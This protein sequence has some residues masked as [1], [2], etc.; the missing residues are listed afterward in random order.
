MNKQEILK[1]YVKEAD[2]LLVA[3]ILDKVQYTNTRNKV[4]YSDFL[5][6]Y[7]QKVGAKILKQIDCINVILCGGYE[8]AERK[9]M[10]FL[11]EKLQSFLKV[12][13]K[14]NIIIQDL[15]NVI[16]IKLP[17]DL[18]GKYHHRDYLS[19]LMKLGIRREKL[20]DILVREDGADIL[21]EKDLANYLIVNL[22]ELTRFK[23][24]S[25]EQ[26]NILDLNV[27]PT[28]KEEITII[29]PQLR[30]DVITTELIHGSRT[31]ANELI[32][33]ERV[34]LNYDVKSK[35]S[36]MLKQGDI[37]TIRGKGKFEIG[38]ILSQTLKGKVRLVVKRYVS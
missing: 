23:K 19:G 31:K 4:Q 14:E 13:I 34:L 5:D 22:Q 18:K 30:L 16:S 38:E 21:V 7:E 15:I 10:I 11:P 36:V 3:K 26:K 35:N 1:Q 24:S 28:L 12:P 32:L 6:G 2:K 27:V 33:N 8:E 17:Q 29:V 25:I 9:I 37:L 20:G